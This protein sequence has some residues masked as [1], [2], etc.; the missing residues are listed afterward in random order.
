MFM[1]KKLKQLQLERLREERLTSEICPGVRAEDWVLC[2]LCRHLGYDVA[3]VKVE[4][5]RTATGRALLTRLHLCAEARNSPLLKTTTPG[6]AEHIA[7][8][9][10]ATF[11]TL[12]GLDGIYRVQAQ[13]HPDRAEQVQSLRQHVARLRRIPRN[14]TPDED[15][16]WD[17]VGKWCR[18][19]HLALHP[20]RKLPTEDLERAFDQAKQ[21]LVVVRQ[22]IE[23]LN[24]LQEPLL[25]AAG[26]QQSRIHDLLE[27]LQLRTD[28]HIDLPQTRE[29]LRPR[30]WGLRARLLRRVRE[31]YNPGENLA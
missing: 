18:E 8:V 28:R 6:S 1:N 15:W 3:Q 5:M 30:N 17:I 2:S 10:A 29:A 12:K 9:Q 21:E 11:P 13:E 4:Y 7:A 16:V 25:E 22:E 31:E 24:K 26:Y 19:R 23:Q 27:E 14:T 20:N